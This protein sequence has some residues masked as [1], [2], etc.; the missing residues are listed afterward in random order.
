VTAL[1]EEAEG[2]SAD[3]Q[4]RCRRRISIDAQPPAIRALVH[5]FGWNTVNAFL[6]CGV[7]NHRHILH[8]IRTIADGAS[9]YGNSNGGPLVR[10][11]CA[12]LGR[13]VRAMHDDARHEC[14]AAFIEAA[15]Q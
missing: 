1:I 2:A 10:F 12:E 14:I 3:W 5:E 7:R 4:E 9:L 15:S 8:L 6:L 11:R 13:I